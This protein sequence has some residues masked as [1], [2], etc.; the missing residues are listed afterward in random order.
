MSKNIVQYA[1]DQ[2]NLLIGD[3]VAEEIK[4]KI[5]SA[6]TLNEP[7]VMAMRGRDLVSGLPREIAVNDTQ[8][9]EALSRSIRF[10]IDNIK[11]TLEVTPPELV[12]DVY[13]RGIVLSGGG[14][15]LTNLDE[16]IAKEIQIPVRIAD[17]PIACVARGTGALLDNPALLRDL[18]LPSATEDRQAFLSR[19]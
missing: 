19:I 17:D 13:E 3:K 15:L 14:A 18:A 4:M 1:R 8:I 7:L 9:R 6:A 5:G 10:L 2:F 16:A 11:A 12:A